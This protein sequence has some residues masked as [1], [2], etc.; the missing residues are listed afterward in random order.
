MAVY[1]DIDA[2]ALRAYLTEA[3]GGEMRISTYDERVKRQI[4]IGE[5]LMDEYRE[6]F[7]LLAK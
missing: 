4:A 6:T 5:Q 1:T 2:S 7:R 3:P